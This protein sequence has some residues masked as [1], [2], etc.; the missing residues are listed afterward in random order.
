MVTKKD[1]PDMLTLSTARFS[2]Q[3][4]KLRTDT[5]NTLAYGIVDIVILVFQL[6]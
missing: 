1:P 5:E 6:K 4:A 2:G 3:E